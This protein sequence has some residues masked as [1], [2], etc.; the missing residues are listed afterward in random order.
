MGKGNIIPCN[1]K[2]RASKSNKESSSYTKAEDI[3]I[4]VVTINGNYRT[5]QN[6]FLIKWQRSF[7]YSLASTEINGY[8]PKAICCTREVAS[9]IGTSLHFVYSFEQIYLISRSTS[10][11]ILSPPW[12][13]NI[14][15]KLYDDIR[16]FK[17][18]EEFSGRMTMY[19]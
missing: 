10:S 14:I 13:E 11:T 6:I 1:K 3:A 12:S 8:V 2:N 17:N 19:I 16:A 18:V 5:I 15:M 7:P 4:L 9:A